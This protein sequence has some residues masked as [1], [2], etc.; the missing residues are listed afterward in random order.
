[1]TSLITVSNGKGKTRRCDA[2]CH[3]AKSEK[4]SCICKG[5]FH[6]KGSEQAIKE[7]DK[8]HEKMMKMFKRGNK[9]WRV[10]ALKVQRDL[11]GGL[12]PLKK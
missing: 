4:C 7:F 3:N 1:M 8:A 9:G 12:T 10:E 6:G 2:S 5:R 11:F